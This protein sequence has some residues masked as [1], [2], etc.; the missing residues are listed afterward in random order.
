M[1]AWK[2]QAA[3]AVPEKRV[4]HRHPDAVQGPV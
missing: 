1:G 2:V 4:R 3:E